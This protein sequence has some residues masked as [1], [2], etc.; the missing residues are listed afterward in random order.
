MLYPR[1]IRRPCSSESQRFDFDRRGLDL[2][3]G[4]FDRCSRPTR[5]TATGC[6]TPRTRCTPRLHPP[7]S[8][9]NCRVRPVPASNDAPGS[10]VS[11]RAGA[12]LLG[13][14]AIVCC[15]RLGIL[16]ADGAAVTGEHFVWLAVCVVAAAFSAACAVVAVLAAAGS[17]QRGEE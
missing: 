11:A 7:R 1:G 5:R 6:G 8:V 10:P 14:V 17:E 15:V 16:S 13:A 2:I 9:R 4:V 3:A 12:Y